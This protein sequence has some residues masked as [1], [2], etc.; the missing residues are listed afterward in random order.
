VIGSASRFSDQ[1]TLYWAPA[2]VPHRSIA[3]WDIDNYDDPDKVVG[4]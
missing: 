2:S 3:H 1:A 4:P